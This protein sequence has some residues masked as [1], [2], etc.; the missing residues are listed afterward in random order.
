[1]LAILVAAVPAHAAAAQTGSLAPPIAGVGDEAYWAGNSVTGSLYALR[2]D[3]ILR[4][5]AGGGA[6]E[7]AK[8][9]KAKKLAQLAIKRLG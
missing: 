6:S 4:V 5:S 3:R 8:I 1:M 2:G 7:Q 9:E